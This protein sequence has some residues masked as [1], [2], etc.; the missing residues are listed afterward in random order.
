MPRLFFLFPSRGVV[1]VHQSCF[2]LLPELWR[3]AHANETWPRGPG[4]R[5]LV[6]VQAPKPQCCDGWF[7]FVLVFVGC[8]LKATAALC[9]SIIFDADGATTP[10]HQ[11]R[12]ALHCFVAGPAL[13]FNIPIHPSPSCCGAIWNNNAQSGQT[14]QPRRAFVG[15]P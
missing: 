3:S 8:D 13:V 6:D 14:F 12:A 10:C 11:R 1:V 5:N 7:S 9:R 2:C 4:R 15:R